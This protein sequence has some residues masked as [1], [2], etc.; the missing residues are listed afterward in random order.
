MK[1]AAGFETIHRSCILA[2]MTALGV[3]TS[4]TSTVE[5]T[6][7]T[8]TAVVNGQSVCDISILLSEGLAMAL[9]KSVEAAVDSCNMPGLKRIRG[10]GMYERDAAGDC[11]LI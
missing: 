1:A 5:I 8:A 9:E 4:A 3:C 6:V 7:A 2:R 11:K 10:V